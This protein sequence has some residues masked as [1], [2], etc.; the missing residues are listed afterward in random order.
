M[1]TGTLIRAT[2]VLLLVSGCAS[3]RIDDLARP[4]DYTEADR[5][6]ERQNVAIIKAAQTKELDELRADI[7]ALKTPKVDEKQQAQEFEHL[8]SLLRLNDIIAE[9]KGELVRQ[10]QQHLEQNKNSVF[11]GIRGKGT[12]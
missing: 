3:H 12:L 10:F 2:A 11:T 8:V 9:H 7:A 1:R 6:F 4:L 5:E